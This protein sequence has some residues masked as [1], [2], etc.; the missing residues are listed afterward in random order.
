MRICTHPPIR[1]SYFFS[2]DDRLPYTTNK[3]T[4]I[5]VHI[6]TARWL[7]FL[8]D[9]ELPKSQGKGSR[10]ASLTCD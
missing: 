2:D 4:R 5:D 7:Y 10:V 3:V 6:E 8:M 9:F 1:S